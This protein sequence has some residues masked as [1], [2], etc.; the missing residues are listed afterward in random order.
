MSDIPLYKALQTSF[1][2]L[3]ARDAA[4]ASVQRACLQQRST[5]GL[6]KSAKP[7]LLAPQKRAAAAR[8]E[9]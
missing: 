3:L 4:A 7:K 9:A 1:F 8:E 2:A 6:E 5:G